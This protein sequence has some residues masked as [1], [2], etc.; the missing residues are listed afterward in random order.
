MPELPDCTE[1]RKLADGARIC[2]FKPTGKYGFMF[3]ENRVK[4]GECPKEGR[5]G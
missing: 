5:R 2:G 4:F 1:Y 3:C